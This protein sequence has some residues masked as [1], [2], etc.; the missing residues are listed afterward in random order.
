MNYTTEL[1]L[2]LSHVVALFAL[3]AGLFVAIEALP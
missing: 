3:T 2:I 1:V